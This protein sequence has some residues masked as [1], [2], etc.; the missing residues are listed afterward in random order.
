ML[1]SIQ[2]SHLGLQD[3]DRPTLGSREPATSQPLD[4]LPLHKPGLKSTN[5]QLLLLFG[6]S[7][8]TLAQ[9]CKNMRGKKFETHPDNFVTS[10]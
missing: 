2:F 9:K 8:E 6:S 3:P 7:T 5:H 1:L 10:A 4:L